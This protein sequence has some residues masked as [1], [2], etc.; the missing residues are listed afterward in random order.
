MG[1]YRYVEFEM[2]SNKL[3]AYSIDDWQ[4]NIIQALTVQLKE[5]EDFFAEVYKFTF[6]FAQETSLPEIQVDMAI[7]LWRIFMNS[8]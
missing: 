6:A 2:I 8:R 1:Q 5:D 7:N 4:K 3:E